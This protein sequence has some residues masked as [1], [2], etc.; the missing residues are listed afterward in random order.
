MFHRD[1]RWVPT[2]LSPG[3]PQQKPTHRHSLYRIPHPV[4]LPSSPLC[5]PD[6]LPN[7]DKHPDSFPK[8]C[9]GRN[10]TKMGMV[11]SHTGLHR[12]FFFNQQ[13]GSQTFSYQHISRDCFSSPSP[14]VP[15]SIY[16]V[17]FW[18]TFSFLPDNVA[19]SSLGH[20]SFCTWANQSEGL[21]SRSPITRSKAKGR[22]LIRTQRWLWSSWLENRATQTQGHCWQGGAR[23]PGEGLPPPHQRFY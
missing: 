7:N 20:L 14:G 17:L 22:V 3:C 9:F 6:H 16:P 13:Y 21:L 23:V 10:P 4:S 11:R 18:R 2:G 8:V 19:V 1:P 12:T 15:C 5:F